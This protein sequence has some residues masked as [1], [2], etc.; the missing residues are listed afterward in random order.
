LCRVDGLTTE[1]VYKYSQK[2]KNP[3]FSII[4]MNA[5]GRLSAQ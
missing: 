1:Y 5:N 4:A 2:L 3:T